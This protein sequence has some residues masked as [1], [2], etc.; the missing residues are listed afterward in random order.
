MK[1]KVRS[2][3][4]KECKLIERQGQW[5]YVTPKKGWLVAH[6]NEAGE[7]LGLAKECM[8]SYTYEDIMAMTVTE[9]DA[10][11]NTMENIIGYYDMLKPA[12]QTAILEALGLTQL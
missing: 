4:E 12:K 10:I 6:S 3:K 7:V 9:L 11:E 5:F 2:G 8:K 1:F